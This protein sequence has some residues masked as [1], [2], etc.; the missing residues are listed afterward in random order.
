ME[1]VA[2]C[3]LLS[4]ICLQHVLLRLLAFRRGE[5]NLESLGTYES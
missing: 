4:M 2:R 5:T 3:Y 1:M